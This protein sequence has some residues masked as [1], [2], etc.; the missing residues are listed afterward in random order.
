MPD[1][2]YI[3]QPKEQQGFGRIGEMIQ[4]LRGA[5]AL[6]LERGALESDIARRKAESARSVTEADVAARTATPR[7]E[8]QA[9]QTSTAQTQARQHAFTLESSQAAKA[10]EI[11]NGLRQDK[12]IQAN[13]ASG[14][15]DAAVEARDQMVAHGIPKHQ[16]EF[17]ASQI[18]SRAHQPGAVTAFLENATR[19]NAGAQTQAGVLNA[20]L[21]VLNTGAGFQPIQTQPGAPGGLQPG[22]APIP[23][24]LPLGERQNVSINPVTSSPMTTTKDAQGNVVGVTPTPAGAGIPQ[25]APGQP[26]DIPILTQARAS[27][28]TAAARVPEARFN[29]AQ[30]IKLVDETDTGRRAEL[31][32]T[33]KGPLAGLPWE[34]QGA[35]K[36]DQLGHFI[37]LEAA[38]NAAAMNAGTDA[39]RSLA[40]QK[41]ASTGWTPSAIKSAVKINDALATGLQNYNKGMEAAIQR[42]GGNVLAVRP[43]QNAWSQAFDPNVYR[44]ANALE[45][46]DKGEIDKIL[47]PAGSA[48]RKAKAAELARKSAV[49]YRLSNEGQ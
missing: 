31:V 3:A 8:Q 11:A 33:L 14:I 38:N 45:A 4:T 41:T 32:R 35:T 28:N 23:A 25:L 34:T 17:W 16:A 30:I 26:Q 7:V 22:G 24:Q 36:F 20:P 6:Q 49:L 2:S 18:S 44:Y 13:D 19:S 29:N 10:M 12:R 15:I 1:Y 21:Q 39:A 48:Q 43:F 46:N 27:T 5:T 9:A 42:N 47:G 40:E 37:A